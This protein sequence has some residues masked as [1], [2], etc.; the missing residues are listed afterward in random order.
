MPP[1]PTSRPISER[2]GLG[3]PPSRYHSLPVET[4]ATPLRALRCPG[5]HWTGKSQLLDSGLSLPWRKSPPACWLEPPSCAPRSHG[6][7]TGTIERAKPVLGLDKQ[8]EV[9]A[10]AYRLDCLIR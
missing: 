9:P 3:L 2:S 6:L 1:A 5:V 7:G 4:C 8:V 10:P